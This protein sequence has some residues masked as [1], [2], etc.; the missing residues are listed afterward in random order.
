MRA[1]TALI[2]GIAVAGPLV[3]AQEPVLSRDPARPGVVLVSRLDK[4]KPFS[5]VVGDVLRIALVPQVAP[6]MPYVQPNGMKIIGI[7]GLRTVLTK[8]PFSIEWDTAGYSPGPYHLKAVTI[9]PNMKQVVANPVAV[10]LLKH[11]PVSVTIPEA[12]NPRTKFPIRVA[13]NQGYAIRRAEVSVDGLPAGDLQSLPGDVALD[14]AKM[15]G[16]PHTVLVRVTDE[17]GREYISRPVEFSIAELI[18]LIEPTQGQRTSSGPTGAELRLRAEHSLGDAV[19]TV[20]F[21]CDGQ[22]VGEVFQQPLEFL[23]HRPSLAPGP[24][25]LSA[26]ALEETGG[27]FRSREVTIYAASFAEPAAPA[28]RVNMTAKVPPAIVLVEAEGKEGE[29][30]R[31]AATGFF[32]HSTGYIVTSRHVTEGAGKVFVTTSQ[33]QRILAQIVAQHATEDLAVLR[34]PPSRYAA[35]PLGRDGD[36]KVGLEV[37]AAGFPFAKDLKKLELGVVP[38]VNYGTIS[39]IRP[40]RDRAGAATSVIHFDARIAPGQSG[41]PLFDAATGKVLGVVRSGLVSETMGAT[42]INL[43]VR[44]DVLR[45]LLA[46]SRIPFVEEWPS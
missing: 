1:I 14:P 10:V 25:R 19:K 23:W 38:A 21:Y 46:Q 26:V 31:G 15:S 6:D 27:V 16:G 3:A 17:K 7:P 18:R 9:L 32:I 37:G 11:E 35:M 43:A 24:H 13:A 41:G 8:T 5:A 30:E 33:G 40:T 36:A 34:V 20:E 42:G 44:V 12:P 28:A 2:L 39:A 29:D 22:K 4:D 45:G